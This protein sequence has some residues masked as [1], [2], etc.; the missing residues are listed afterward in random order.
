MEPNCIQVVTP[1]SKR[2]LPFLQTWVSKMAVSVHPEGQGPVRFVHNLV[3]DGLA[4]D[5]AQR[6]LAGIRDSV[7][8]PSGA[9]LRA[10]GLPKPAGQAVARNL[11]L[12]F[13]RW[14]DIVYCWDVDDTPYWD[15]I[16][17]MSFFVDDSTM[18]VGGL[19]REMDSSL[20]VAGP[21][22]VRFEPHADPRMIVYERNPF[23]PGQV[24][25]FASN[26]VG[27]GG[28]E[29]FLVCSEDWLLWRRMLDASPT[30]AYVRANGDF[31]R[32]LWRKSSQSK[33]LHMDHPRSFHLDFVTHGN[34]GARLDEQA[35]RRGSAALQSMALKLQASTFEYLCNGEPIEFYDL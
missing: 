2:D 30:I 4:E 26:M 22:V 20:N 16:A 7:D 28:F 31:T 3:F 23:V 35:Q 21:R 32:Y 25:V 8:Y 34:A 18:V 17:S 12:S 29:P 5:E 10:F 15:N 19:V 11:A 6:V 27:L 14:S 1:V 33:A 24:L 13:L 9:C